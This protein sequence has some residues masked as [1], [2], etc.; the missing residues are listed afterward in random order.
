M[1]KSNVIRSHIF[2][3][4]PH[5]V[6]SVEVTD[7]NGNILCVDIT[8]PTI[9]ALA[10]GLGDNFILQEEIEVTLIN[11][12]KAAEMTFS[13]NEKLS[14]AKD[15]V[16]RAITIYDTSDNVNLFHLKHDG[17]VIDYWLSAEQRNKLLTGV[18]SWSATHDDYTF[19]LRELNISIDIPCNELLEILSKLEVYAVKCQNT[20]SRHMREVN[21]LASIE[22]IVNYDYKSGYPPK[23]TF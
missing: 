14:F 12:E 9:D 5:D 11:L 22:E 19:D 15:M 13:D 20:T 8:E 7:P 21:A 4:N 3:N 16:L 10:R 18:T 2:G 1:K 17:K 23:E 6:Y